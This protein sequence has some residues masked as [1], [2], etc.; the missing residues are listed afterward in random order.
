M[1]TGL[2]LMKWD[3]RL[4]TKIIA[5]YPDEVK[6]TEK[7]MMQIY[8]THEYTGES[9]LVSLNIGALNIASYYTGQENG[10][11][12]IL[13][14][15]LDEDPDVF[16]EGMADSARLILSNMV[17]NTYIPLIPSI[18]QRLS[19]YPSLNEEQKLAMIYTE[20]SKREVF[21]R[22]QEEGSMLKSEISVWLRDQFM[23]EF[24]DVEGIINSFIKQTLV[25]S[26]SVK[27]S[28][29]EV[30]YLVKDL[31]ISRIPPTTLVKEAVSRGL[32]KSLFDSYKTEVT[33]YFSKYV[34]NEQDNIQ[35]LNVLLDP[36]VFE[37]LTL[38]RQ[39]IVTRDDLEKLQKKGVD[40]VD[41]VLKKLWD[42]NLIQVLRD[43]SENEYF[44]LQSDIKIM[45]MLPEYNL[46]LIRNQFSRKVKSKPVQLEYIDALK[47]H[48][49]ALKSGEKDQGKRKVEEIK[50]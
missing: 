19:V 48:F 32:P 50:S 5:K 45:K 25:K 23:D 10:L 43:E 16:E 27:G 33:N 7:T 9:G 1:P 18:F 13:M 42:V 6:I 44:A 4:G 2:I 28:P 35:L 47:D 21:K 31:F 30:I 38:L 40:D 3:E 49:K 20:D 22:L 34:N 15:H 14:L 11:Y 12:L 37:T 29:S 39:A 26:R 36:P 41:D 17:D 24:V 46:N 8:S